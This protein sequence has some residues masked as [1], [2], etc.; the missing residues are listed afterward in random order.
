M[1]DTVLVTGASGFLGHHI[2]PG[3][4]ARGW[5][6]YA[7]ARHPADML[8]APA[9]RAVTLP[10]LSKPVRWEPLLEDVT[11]VVHF[12][13][14]AHAGPGVSEVDF[15]QVNAQAVGDLAHA[16]RN[17]A[18]RIVLASSI[19]A[20]CGPVCDRILT[21]DDPAMPSDPYG[22]SKLRAEQLLAHS[23]APWVALRSVLVYGSGVRGNMQALARL[24]RSPWPLP[25]G[26]LSN[27]RSLLAVENL[28]SAIDVALRSDAALGKSFLVADAGPVTLPQ[29]IAAL[30]RGLN[31]RPG[32]LPVPPELLG[33]M[34][35]ATG[36]QDAWLRLSG[37]LVVDTS[38][39]QSTGW[40]PSVAT[41]DALAHMM[42]HADA[43]RSAS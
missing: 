12:A 39:L 6:V 41:E 38:A 21:E 36:R 1:T 35:Q 10:D 37:D 15:D 20:Q 30:R 29:I 2:V 24:A 26:A 11:H 3:L 19:R 42:A 4:A 40:R 13:G 7:A 23:G 27:R 22:R 33:R 9:A 8:D 5:R 16:A 14:I 32:L 31:R 28:I 17:R 25:F 34:M 18:R 43:G